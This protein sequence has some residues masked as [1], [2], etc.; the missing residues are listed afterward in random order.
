MGEQRT[1]LCAALRYCCCYAYQP[2]KLGCGVGAA[3]C[4]GDSEG[5]TTTEA[6]PVG[7][8]P[9]FMDDLGNFWSMVA[10]PVAERCGR[11]SES[12]NEGFGKSCFTIGVLGVGEGS[13]W[14]GALSLNDG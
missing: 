14:M 3:C 5:V 13:Y 11:D 1:S 10:E 6:G 2:L 9:P 4:V 12:L 8:P 7:P